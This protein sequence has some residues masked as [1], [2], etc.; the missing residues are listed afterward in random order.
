MNFLAHLY[1]SGKNEKIMVGN[2]LADFVKGKQALSLFD[3]EIKTGIELHRAIDLFTD[4]H[5]VVRESKNRL[6][7]KYR[8]Y[9]AVIVDVFYDHCL[10]RNWAL[11]STVVLPAFAD[12]AYAILQKYYSVLPTRLQQML[13][14]MIRGNWLV[15]YAKPEGIARTL[16]GMS[17]RTPYESKMDEAIDELIKYY[18][19]FESEFNLFFP[20][21]QNEVS[22]F[23]KRNNIRV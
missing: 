1:L 10:A 21:L 23:L 7:E 16:T 19:D 9:S 13:P 4:T 2:F 20:D 8:H 11:Y 15:N 22:D 5:P 14:Y 3:G 12:E 18:S 17:R 6:R